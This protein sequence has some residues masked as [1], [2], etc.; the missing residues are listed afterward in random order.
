[1]LSVIFGDTR[2]A[3]HDG[4]D[5]AS[6]GRLSF[7][8]EVNGTAGAWP[9][10]NLAPMPAGELSPSRRNLPP[11]RHVLQ[12]GGGRKLEQAA[13]VLKQLTALPQWRG[14]TITAVNPAHAPDESAAFARLNDVL[15]D[16]PWVIR[17]TSHIRSPGNWLACFTQAAN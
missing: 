3:S 11:S 15:A 13:F 17:D 9:N 1:V 7:R 2:L 10:S 12:R 14:L 6:A 8:R 16:A 5:A 4:I